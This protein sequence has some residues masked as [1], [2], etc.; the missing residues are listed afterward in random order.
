MTTGNGPTRVGYSME[1]ST[2]LLRCASCSSAVGM[3]PTGDVS[4]SASDA[5]EACGF[6]G[7]SEAHAA[8]ASA[9]RE[10]TIRFIETSGYDRMTARARCK[11][12]GRRGACDTL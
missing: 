9:A 5:A 12:Q 6:F 8:T 11:L 1:T 7:W 3:T 4:P 10:I 2:S